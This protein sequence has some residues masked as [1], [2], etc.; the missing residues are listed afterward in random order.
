MKELRGNMKKSAAKKVALYGCFLAFAMIVAY[1]EVILPFS[2]GIPGTKLGLANVVI[3]SCLYMFGVAPALTINLCRIVLSA[4]LFGNLYSMLY[5]FSGAVFSF[6]IMILL[7]RC[8]G[9]TVIG[10]SI[11]GGVAHNFGQILIAVLITKVPVLV[12]YVPVLI[13]VGSLTGLVNGWL[14]KLMNDRIGKKLIKDGDS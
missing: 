11:A 2:I 7:K 4:L 13:L 1:I 6:V 12:Y 9:F 3:V 8:K 14:A 5:A 10:V